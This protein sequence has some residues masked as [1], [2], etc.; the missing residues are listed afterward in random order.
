MKLFLEFMV[1]KKL[2]TESQLLEVL[3]EQISTTPSLP[4]I[5][6]RHQ[7]LEPGKILAALGL[8]S[9][10]QKDFKTACVELGFW[11]EKI[12]LEIESKLNSLRVPVETLLL[13]KKLV[14]PSQLSLVLA[15]YFKQSEKK[16]SDWL[17]PSQSFSRISDVDSEI[18]LELVNEACKNRMQSLL[19][20]LPGDFYNVALKIFHEFHFVKSAAVYFNLELTKNLAETAEDILKECLASSQSP[21]PATAEI[22]QLIKDVC[23]MLWQTRDVLLN[24]F[25]EEFAWTKLKDDL[26]RLNSDCNQIKTLLNETVRL[27]HGQNLSSR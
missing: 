23:A 2:I 27:D 18:F 8:Q 5:L 21:P 22:T 13:Q 7:I 6:Y 14:S 20:D 19:S 4:V 16:K 26:V 17:E 1:E 24:T 12:Q 9:K 11:N 15:E 3:I 25:S 10:S